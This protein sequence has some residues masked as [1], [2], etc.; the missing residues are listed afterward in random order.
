MSWVQQWL[1]AL[2]PLARDWGYLIVFLVALFEHFIFLGLIVPGDAVLLLGALYAG[3][4][5]LN[6]VFVIM[7]AFLGSVA[8][9]NLGYLL[10]LKLGRPILDRYGDFMRLR[11]R[12][13][14]VERYFDRYGPITIFIARFATFVGTFVSPVAGLSR[15]EYRKFLKYEVLGSFVWAVGYGLIGFFFGKNEQLILRIF[16]YIGNTLLVIMI[17]IAVTAYVV[18]KIRKRRE[19]QEELDR[20]EAEEEESPGGAAVENSPDNI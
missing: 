20:L 19:I 4:G 1:E 8:G 12:V 9:D 15:M 17:V 16:S 5:E 13:V 10:G 3:M 2:E 6:I 11:A 18:H 7:L 14:Y